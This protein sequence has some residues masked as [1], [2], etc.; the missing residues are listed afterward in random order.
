[1]ASAG[2]EP[3]GGEAE[4]G[5]ACESWMLQDFAVRNLEKG[6]RAL[7]QIHPNPL[8]HR[9]MGLLPK[10][11]LLPKAS[12]DDESELLRIARAAKFSISFNALRGNATTPFKA[13]NVAARSFC[14]C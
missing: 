2:G 9:S 12:P 14:S 13:D 6:R 7:Y 5:D 4:G 8:N 11:T 1:M 10:T 3:D